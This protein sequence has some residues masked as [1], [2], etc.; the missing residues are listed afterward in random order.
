[1]EEAFSQI[2]T[3]SADAAFEVLKT[4]RYGIG[5]RRRLS[6]D[7]GGGSVGA[8]GAGNALAIAHLDRE[9]VD[10]FALA[11]I[12]SLTRIARDGRGCVVG[13]ARSLKVS[14]HESSRARFPVR[15]VCSLGARSSPPWAREMR[16][17]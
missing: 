2:E 7:G 12:A 9:K 13:R 14:R 8:G 10:K 16:H 17:T 4:T 11:D 15:N 3:A 5:Q 6:F 1:M